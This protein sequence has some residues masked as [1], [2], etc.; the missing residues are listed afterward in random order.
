MSRPRS[1]SR[2][3]LLDRTALVLIALPL[4][5]AAASPASAHPLAPM[6]LEITEQA[7]GELRV[8]W[9]EPLLRTPQS[10]MAP[11]MPRHCRTTRPATAKRE[12]SGMLY[13]WTMSCGGG[14]LTGQTIGI[15]GLRG[16]RAN[17]LLRVELRDG[18]QIREL[19]TGTRPELVIPARMGGLEVARR[20]LELGTTHLLTGWDHLLFILGLM[21]LVRGP[22]ALI[23][24]ISCFT[25]GHAL[26]LSLAALGF[27]TFDAGAIEVL[28]ALSLVVLAAEL[29][30]RPSAGRRPSW[31][32]RA[33]WAMALLFGL[34]HG[35]GFASAL[36]EIGLPRSDIPLA[37]LAFNLGIEL[38]QL[39]FIAAVS[40]LWLALSRAAGGLPPGRALETAGWSRI[41]TAYGIGTLAA[42]WCIRQAWAFV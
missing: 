2:R 34:L 38:G 42:Y 17:V 40:V 12:G 25:L 23:A 8:R 36:A 33:P 27:V 1:R 4:L 16:N 9:K 20:Y 5:L 32:R 41:L 11:A 35:L 15:T 31:L 26:T 13:E 18:G 6:L 30:H 22:R 24:T 21:L 14:A 29:A 28:I 7:G 10:E 3:A 19:L 39:V 37:L